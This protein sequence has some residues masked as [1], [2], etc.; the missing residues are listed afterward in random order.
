MSEQTYLLLTRV[1]VLFSPSF[2]ISHTAVIMSR[3]V[4]ISFSVCMGTQ[5]HSK[6]LLGH[7]CQIKCS[8][9]SHTEHSHSLK[10]T[11]TGY[12]CH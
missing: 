5:V 7:F 3:G 8:L 12:Y 1:Q 10:H 2:S 11:V 4:I 9:K 6:M